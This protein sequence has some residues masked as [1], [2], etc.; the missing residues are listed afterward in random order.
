MSLVYGHADE[1]F[2]LRQLARIA[3]GGMGAIQ[4]ELKTLAEAGIIR[5]IEKGKQIYYQAN[6]QC[7]V[8]AELKSLIMKTAGMGDILKMVLV[9]LAE[10]IRIAFIYGSLA[11]S[12][13]SKS[14]DVDIMIIGDVSFA[15][16]VA[17]LSPAQQNLNREI[18]PSVYPV[19]EF[20]DKL[21][22]GHHF[23][24][25]VLEGDKWFLIGDEHDLARLA[26]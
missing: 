3:G 12:D 10:R 11:R 5:R 16:V 2:Y 14:S 25:S 21:V 7:P 22:K 4:R 15:D 26:K 8:F 17:A 18:N 6:P 24:Q 13:E 19:K 23:L 20:K 1:T 9:P